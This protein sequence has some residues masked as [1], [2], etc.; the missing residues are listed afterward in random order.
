M[1]P[2]PVT[3]P[4][5]EDYKMENALYKEIDRLKEINRE[6]VEACRLAIE[7]I[8]S[9]CEGLIPIATKSVLTRTLAKAGKS[10]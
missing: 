8:D 3:C 5:S 1:T 4:K 9:Y 2:A 6:L 7:C 10:E